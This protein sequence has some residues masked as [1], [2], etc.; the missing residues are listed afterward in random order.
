VPDLLTFRS[1]VPDVEVRSES[2]REVAIRFMRWGSIGRTN[3]GPEVFE[4]G[5]FDDTVPES[6]VLRME[7]EGP[8]AGR[9]VLLERR[10]QQDG[11][12]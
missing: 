6:V 5:A 8:P 7:H 9:G 2:K 1:D 10:R 3:E 11:L 4:A 12:R